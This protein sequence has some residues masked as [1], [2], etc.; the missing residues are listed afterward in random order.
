[1]RTDEAG[2]R[3]GL[4][5]VVVQISRVF[6]EHFLSKPFSVRSIAACEKA[7]MSNGLRAE[8]GPPEDEE[9]HIMFRKI[10]LSAAVAGTAI[11]ALPAAAQAQGYGRY[12]RYDGYAYAQQY[13]GDRYDRRYD[14]RRYDRRYYDQRYQGRYGRRC[15]G[16]TGTIIGA[17][18]G[19]L[20]GRAIDGGRDRAAG[21]IIGGA[22][23]ALAG[24]AI[25]RD[26]C[27]R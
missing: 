3:V 27:R 21:T 24:R 20:L 11:A 19:G 17:I 9:M 2:L 5:F 25:D 14:Q 26:Q 13:R 22:A 16:T 1:L 15:S 23:G 18:A 7:C 8:S 6:P 10:I 12:D 4:F